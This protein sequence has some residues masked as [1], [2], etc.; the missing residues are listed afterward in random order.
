MP[1][2]PYDEIKTQINR[3]LVAGLNKNFDDVEQDVRAL[4]EPL[5]ALI[6][7]NFNDAALTTMFEERAEAKLAEI[8]PEF[9]GFQNSTAAQ[10]ALFSR[11]LKHIINVDPFD[12]GAK[13]YADDP[14][15]DNTPVLADII[16]YINSK[17]GYCNVIYPAGE[18][19]FKQG[20][21]PPILANEANFIGDGFDITRFI[22]Q[23]STYFT[24]GNDSFK[25]TYGGL[26]G[27]TL[28]YRL[29]HPNLTSPAVFA[30]NA[31]NQVYDI[32]WSYGCTFLVCGDDV[33]RA[34]SQTIKNAS[35]MMANKGK[36]FVQLVKGAGFYWH[37]FDR[38]SHVEAATPTWGEGVGHEMNTVPGTNAVDI[39]GDWDTVELKIF[40]EKLWRGINIDNPTGVIYNIRDFG[41]VYD[42]MRDEAVHVHLGTSG[43]VVSM[44][45][46]N[47]YITTWE[48]HGI[49]IVSLNKDLRWLNIIN[50]NILYTGKSSIYIDGTGTSVKK[51]SI[52]GGE[53]RGSGRLDGSHSVVLGKYLKEFKIDN[54]TIGGNDLASNITWG[55]GKGLV[56]LLPNIDPLWEKYNITNNLLEFDML[57]PDNSSQPIQANL[58]KGII[59]GNSS[60]QHA[61]FRTGYPYS[62]PSSGQAWFN[63]TPYE[64]EVFFGGSDI[65]SIEKNNSL[66]PF[67]QGSFVVRPGESFKVNYSNVAN[68]KVLFNVLN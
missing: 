42:Y 26:R 30:K 6:D 27:M 43:S 35:V 8:A 15:F 9:Y 50:P 63:I 18:F 54:A 33:N 48:G 60:S 47:T 3:E 58:R 40:A 46:I 12:F 17:S 23:D 13:S 4:N 44:Y 24:F 49:Y 20:D 67:V 45:L 41:S 66:I 21:V 56:T 31:A 65:V 29:D 34:D 38:I 10:M 28:Q 61:G 22:L 5:Q 57:V 59:K 32:K 53:M 36:P 62:V 1:N 52:V 25:A 37:T 11:K 19:H 14:T 68:L 7:G 51:F 16:N 64:V 2:Y 55:A 39:T